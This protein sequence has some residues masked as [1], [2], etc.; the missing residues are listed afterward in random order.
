MLVP[1]RRGLEGRTG[2]V[3][4]PRGLA[5]RRTHYELEDLVLA[6]P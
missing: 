1:F 4:L 3:V 5:D 2:R 6:E